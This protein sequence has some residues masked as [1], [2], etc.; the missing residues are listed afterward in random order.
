MCLFLRSRYYLRSTLLA[1]LLVL[2]TLSIGSIKYVIFLVIAITH[3]DSAW[4]FPGR[5]VCGTVQ[6][7]P[8]V[9]LWL[10]IRALHANSD[11]GLV[12]HC[13][14]KLTCPERGQTLLHPPETLRW[15]RM[16]LRISTLQSIVLRQTLGLQGHITYER[17]QSLKR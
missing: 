7:L 9:L 3:L 8:V 15:Q 14:V 11:S 2:S 1:E 13:Q 17:C 10:S 12:S 5:S 4:H 6:C 16:L